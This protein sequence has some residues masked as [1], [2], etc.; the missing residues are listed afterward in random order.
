MGGLRRPTPQ[1]PP[2]PPQP[3]PDPNFPIPD[4][5]VSDLAQY[6]AQQPTV[7]PERF[8]L[9]P[10]FNHPSLPPH[11]TPSTSNPAQ[12]TSKRQPPLPTTHAQP[13]ALRNPWDPTSL[14]SIPA[15]HPPMPPD[16]FDLS[17][18]LAADPTPPGFVSRAK[19]ARKVGYGDYIQL[20]NRFNRDQ[21][22]GASNVS[23]D[24]FW[25]HLIA[26]YFAPEATL[27]IDLISQNTKESQSIKVPVEAL[28]RIWESKVEAGTKE[29]RTLMEDPCEY[30]LPSGVV[31]VDCL[32]TVIITKYEH[33]VV[34][35]DGH[36]RV[37]FHRNKKILAWEFSTTR[38]E[39]LVSKAGL[40]AGSPLG[41]SL[42]EFGIP[43]S[44]VLQMTIANDL[45]S[46]RDK[47]GQ[48]VAKIAADPQKL[49]SLMNLVGGG[50]HGGDIFPGLSGQSNGTAYQA[51]S[52]VLDGAGL[53]QGIAGGGMAAALTVDGGGAGSRAF[54]VNFDM[55]GRYP[56]KNETIVP[57]LRDAINPWKHEAQP[58]IDQQNTDPTSAEHQQSLMFPGILDEVNPAILSGEGDAGDRSGRRGH[59]D[60]NLPG[61]GMGGN[62][63][64]L[65]RRPSGQSVIDA[66]AAAASGQGGWGVGSSVT[67]DP[68]TGDGGGGDQ[69]ANLQAIDGSADA[70]L[71]MQRESGTGGR[72]G[73]VRQGAPPGLAMFTPQGTENERQKPTTARRPRG[74]RGG[75]RR[76]GSG[77][78]RGGG[79]MQ[80]LKDYNGDNLRAMQRTGRGKAKREASFESA[81]GGGGGGTERGEF[82]PGS[83]DQNGGVGGGKKGSRAEVGDGGKDNVQS[84]GGMRRGAARVVADERADNRQ[85]AGQEAGQK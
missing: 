73:G 8:L 40:T 59:G 68:G 47:I 54:P 66:V 51:I 24:R 52:S 44:V 16:S 26:N 42:S 6:S 69:D 30:L 65:R 27:H 9:D 49:V 82:G 70:I 77:S 35:T 56:M 20:L 72:S 36:L 83:Q 28:P 39:E 38:H 37:S 3:P 34:L 58:V 63:G 5:T 2:P 14:I 74:S 78:S 76:G 62:V 7:D 21:R 41:P 18:D 81:R 67:G 55:G 19:H 84:T 1:P 23:V 50:V 32:T 10:T 13:N 25:K 31:V 33:S 4:P 22:Q 46:M 12:F 80:G 43:F 57:N 60:L 53:D 85:K 61:K 71:A 48:E 17:D 79:H 45:H 29:E 15:A 11:P 64:D 75:S